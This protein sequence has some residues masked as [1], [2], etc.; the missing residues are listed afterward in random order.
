MLAAHRDQNDSYEII[1]SAYQVKKMNNIRN[2][3]FGLHL[4][5]TFV[6]IKAEVGMFLVKCERN[7]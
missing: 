4:W 6:S 7:L 1:M 2:V 5:E 3:I